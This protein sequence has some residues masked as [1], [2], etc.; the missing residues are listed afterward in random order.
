[1]AA[2]IYFL[3]IAELYKRKDFYFVRIKQNYN[4][5]HFVEILSV[6]KSHL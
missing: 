3:I 5:V 2:F 1:M 4:Y 6:E